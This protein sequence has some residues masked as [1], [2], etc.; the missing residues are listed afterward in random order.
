MVSDEAAVLLLL[1]LLLLDCCPDRTVM[2]T[3][4]HSNTTEKIRK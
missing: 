2:N 1:L 4:R 3:I